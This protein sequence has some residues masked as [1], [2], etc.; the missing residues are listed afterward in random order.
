ML[1]PYLRFMFQHLYISGS[2]AR[3]TSRDSCLSIHI[4]FRKLCKIHVSDSYFSIFVFQD[5]LQ[6]PY[7]RI[8]VSAFLY[9]RTLCKIHISG[10]IYQHLHK[11]QSGPFA[12]SISPDLCLSIF[13]S[14]DP[15]QNPY[16]RIHILAPTYL[17]I[18]CKIHMTGS[19]L[20]IQVSASI[21]ISG[22]SARSMLPDP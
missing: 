17:R 7:L 16:L 11:C 9:L 10:S 19:C 2:S 6:D 13:A 22:S 15:R 20:S 18:L 21:C 5:P 14:Q 12:K 8:H 1:D 3:S 4:Y